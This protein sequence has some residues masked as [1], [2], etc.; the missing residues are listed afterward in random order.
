MSDEVNIHVEVDRSDPARTRIVETGLPDLDANQ[1]RLRIDRFALTANNVTYALI[2]ASLGYWDFFPTSDAAFGRV[3]AMGFAEVVAS[4]H[5]DVATGGRY[6]GWYPF[7]RYVDLT[8]S[9]T[10]E[11]LRDDGA[12]RA[13]HAP[14]YR[15]YTASDRD[16]FYQ[17][18]ADGEDR[19]A[20]LRGLYLTGFLADDFFADQDD[21]GARRA[22]VIS[23]SSKTAIAFAQ[24]A[25]ERGLGE[26]IGVTSERNRD[27]VAGL[28]WYDRVVTYD[29]IEEI[30]TDG[31]AVSI[32]MSGNGEVLGRL[33]AHLEDRLRYSMLVGLSH[34]GAPPQPQ[35]LKGP[36][37]EFFFAPTQV[38]KRTKDW[39]PKDFQDRAAAALAGFIEGSR[40]W[41]EV[42]HSSGPDAVQQVWDDT[43]AGRVPPRIG[44]VV[45]LGDT[46]DW[47]PTGVGR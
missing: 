9:A 4:A 20:L 42:V 8:V 39:G 14:V 3:P 11:G 1:V 13:A 43:V 31:E 7:S 2:G 33:H 45:T 22:I 17:A 6:Y 18:G 21:F 24:R 34:V 25:S 10:G 27:F 30:P 12:H 36:Q 32:D 47:L 23:A 28:P 16:A 29:A 40:G 26:V 46:F 38:S 35:N 15:S 41:L 5:P 19:V 44:H 37:P